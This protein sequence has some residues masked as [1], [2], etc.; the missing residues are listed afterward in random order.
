VAHVTY[1]QLQIKELLM[2]VF[3]VSIIAVIEQ[4]TE[5]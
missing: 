3:N 1:L 4:R 5:I 2:I